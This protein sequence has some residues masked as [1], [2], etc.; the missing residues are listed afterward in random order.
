MG[1]KRNE[2]KNL[3]IINFFF[4]LFFQKH[5]NNN[6][7]WKWNE[8]QHNKNIFKEVKKNIQWIFRCYY[9]AN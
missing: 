5:Y 6:K 8:M 7:R 9:Q 4:S 2:E 3:I 1:K